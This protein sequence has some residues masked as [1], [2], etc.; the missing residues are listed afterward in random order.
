MTEI[1]IDKVINAKI[2]VNQLYQT[3]LSTSF[4]GHFKS[5]RSLQFHHT[6]E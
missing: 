5:C 6:Y 2:E 3:P 1:D 4:D